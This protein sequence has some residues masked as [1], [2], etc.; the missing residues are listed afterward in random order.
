MTTI[1]DLFADALHTHMRKSDYTIVA[2][3]KACGVTE[4][5]VYRWR[6]GE[7]STLDSI[8]KA[9]HVLNVHPAALLGA[10]RVHADFVHFWKGRDRKRK[11]A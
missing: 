7:T 6:R 1:N 2:F 3:A 11:A 5:T 9:A 8:A 10:T 4:N